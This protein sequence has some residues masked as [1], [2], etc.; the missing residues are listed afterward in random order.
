M[1]DP[2]AQ[3]SAYRRS[4]PWEMSAMSYEGPATVI[5]DDGSEFAVS[6]V[7]RIHSMDSLAAWWGRVLARDGDLS[8]L[9]RASSATLLLPNGRDGTFIADRFDPGQPDRMSIRGSGPPPY[10]AR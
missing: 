2:R 6:A 1:V 5:L 4:K 9:R 7:I 8:A 10:G 3:A